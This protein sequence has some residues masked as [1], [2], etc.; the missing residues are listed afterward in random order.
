MR[1]G[2]I[3]TRCRLH[4]WPRYLGCI[5]PQ[6]RPHPSWLVFLFPSFNVLIVLERVT[7]LLLTPWYTLWIARAHQLVM[8]G[9]NWSH[10]R[11]VVTIFSAPN[12]CY[13][14][15]NQAAIMEIDENNKFTLYV[16]CIPLIFCSKKQ[17]PWQHTW[18]PYSRRCSLQF[19]PAPRAGEPL[20]SRRVPD[21]SSPYLWYH[22]DIRW[23]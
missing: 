16:S 15:G 8:E 3:T 9:Y 11:N 22:C 14:C 20:V 7:I 23:L 12:Y 6:Q 18:L 5:Q 10:E 13:R 19:D 21:V 17:Y 4:L 2:H 1:L